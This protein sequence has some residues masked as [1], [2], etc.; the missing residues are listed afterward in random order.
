VYFS[1]P[2]SI[3]NPVRKDS[4]PSNKKPDAGLLFRAAALKQFRASAGFSNGLNGAL[5]FYFFRMKA[6]GGT[7]LF[8]D[9][10]PIISII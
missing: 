9:K 4:I 7:E 5:P 10:E 6:A 1:S 2:Q 8:L 3:V